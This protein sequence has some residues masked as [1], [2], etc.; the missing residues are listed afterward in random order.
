MKFGIGTAQFI[1][2][3]GYARANIDLLKYFETLNKSKIDMIDTAQVYGK[4]QLEIGKNLK[5]KNK[6]K[7][8]TKIVSMG[9]INKL[10]KLEYFKRNFESSL[11]ELKID[12]IH[13]LLFHDERDIFQNDNFYKYIDN[14]KKYKIIRKFGYSTYKIKNF[15]NNEK[16]YNFNIVQ[17]PLNIFDLNKRKIDFYK[18]IRHKCEIHIRSIFL[19]GML[20]NKNKKFNKKL[21]IIDKKICELDKIILKRNFINRYQYILSSFK[22]LNVAD[23]C[24]IG[25]LNKSEIKDLKNF[26]YKKTSQIDLKKL[27]IKNKKVLDLRKWN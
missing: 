9:K 14:L 22:D 4:A 6:K 23:Y 21:N 10:K 18:K 2:K 3:Y 27:Q 1:K 25:C 7:I 26:K 12:N 20:L 5:R 11:R 13:G 17:A 19:Q 16:I 8:V 15:V 24:I